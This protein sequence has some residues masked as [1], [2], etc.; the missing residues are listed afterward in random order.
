MRILAAVLVAAGLSVCAIA[1]VAYATDTQLTVAVH[2]PHCQG[3]GAQLGVTWQP[4][5]DL[6]KTGVTITTDS[7]EWTWN[8]QI[9]SDANQWRATLNGPLPSKETVVH[10]VTSDGSGEQS[11]PAF[12]GNENCESTT[13]TTT[14]STT[15]TTTTVPVATSSTR[16]NACEFNDTCSDIPHQPQPVVVDELPNTGAS[17]PYLAAIGAGALLVGG[18]AVLVTRTKKRTA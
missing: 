6:S 5:T 12:E 15:S 7:G 4:Q 3:E 17:T 18:S 10:V 9:E 8:G 2:G 1:G 11:I 13:T 14:T 16:V